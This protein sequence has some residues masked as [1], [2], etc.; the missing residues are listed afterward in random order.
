MRRRLLFAF[1]LL[2][3]VSGFSQGTN[4]TSL[5]GPFGGNIRDIAVHPNGNI[6]VVVYNASIVYKSTDNGATWSEIATPSLDPSI[7]D[8][9]IDASG[10][11]YAVSYSSVYS[12]TDLGV[13]WTTLNSNTGFNNPSFIKK[14]G[15]NLFVLAYSNT[16]GFQGVYKSTN[17]ATSFTLVYSPLDNSKMIYEML[18][19]SGGEVLLKAGGGL[20][21]LRSAATGAA[22]YNSS[23]TGITTTSLANFSSGN[24]LIMDAAGAIYAVFNDNV[25]KSTNSGANWTAI[26]K[27]GTETSFNN[28][29]L[30]A[31]PTGTALFIS[32]NGHT[33]Y[34][35]NSGTSW[36]TQGDLSN[37]S[38]IRATS[39][40]NLLVGTNR[41][42]N[43]STNSGANWAE[44]NTGISGLTF[45]DMVYYN[46][47]TFMVAPDFGLSS[48]VDQGANWIKSASS[49]MVNASNY[50]LL[51][52][53]NGNIFSF[54]NGCDK[55]VDGG[56]TWTNLTVP[57]PFND[58]E[59]YDGTTIYA[60]NGT[61][62]YKSI[63]YGVNWGSSLVFTGLPTAYTV[64]NFAVG[65]SSIFIYLRN[66][67]N[68]INELWK[69]S[70]TTLAA[71]KITAITFFN[72]NLQKQIWSRNGKIYFYSRAIGGNTF[73]LSTSTDD[74]VTWATQNVPLSNRFILASNGYPMLAYYTGSIYYSRDDGAN[75]I[76]VPVNYASLNNTLDLKQAIVDS[77]GNLYILLNGYGLL[78]SSK[79]IILPNPPT[80]LTNVGSSHNRISLVWDDNSNNET[81]FVVERSVGTNTQYDSVGV[82]DVSFLNATPSITKTWIQQ[83]G[84]T[85]NTT[86]FLRVKAVNDAGQ[87]IYSN[88][89][90]VTTPAKCNATIPDNR[91]W[92]GVTQNQSGK[93]V[94]TNTQIGIRYLGNG[95]YSISDFTCG[96]YS[97]IGGSFSNTPIM[98]GTFTENCGITHLYTG[99][100]SGGS[101]ILSN[102][103]STW[104][105]GTNTL[106]LKWQT[107]P[108]WVTL[109]GA[110]FSETVVLTL[111]TTDPTPI[112][113][114][115]TNAFVV[116][117]TGIQVQWSA[118]NYQNQYTIE[119]S[120]SP[121]FA[122][123]ISTVGTVNYPNLTIIDRTISF[124]TNT[125][126]YYRLR[127]SN[128]SGIFSG[129]SSIAS[130]V[131]KKPHFVPINT[132]P[133]T[134]DLA[135]SR[136]SAAFIDFDND[137][138]EDL[139]MASNGNIEPS[140]IMKNNGSGGFDKVLT[141]LPPGT[142]VN[143]S[144]ADFN[145]DGKIDFG[146]TR[147][148]NST[149]KAQV[150]IFSGNGDGTFTKVSGIPA[151]QYYFS[152]TFTWLDYNKDGKLDL[153]FPLLDQVSAS[154]G[155]YSVQLH[156]LRNDGANAF[157]DLILLD[158]G[159]GSIFLND[160]KP[161]DYD[162][163]GDQD[164]LLVGL[165]VGGSG[166]NTRM[167]ANDGTGNFST[168]SIPSLIVNGTVEIYSS[169][170]GDIDNDNDL[171][172]FIGYSGTANAMFRNNGNGTFTYLNTNAV[173]EAI[174]SATYGG[175]WGDI[176]NDGDLDLFVSRA[177]S[178]ITDVQFLYLNDGLGNFTRI[179]GEF[180][181]NYF[182]SN[183]TAAFGDYDRDGYLDL[184]TGFADKNNTI[185]KNNKKITTA[186]N[187][188]QIKL[189]GTVSNRSA[190][191]ARVSLTAAG[192][193]ATREIQSNTGPAYNGQNSFIAHFGLGNATSITSITVTWPSGIVQTLNAPPMNQILTIAEDN[194]GPVISTLS[195]TNTATGVS[196]NSNLEITLTDAATPI[197]AVAGKNILIYLSS[198]LTT[199][200]RTI[201]VNT[202]VQSG[203]K[204][205]LDLATDLQY[206]T[207]YSVAIEAGAFKD[208]YGNGNLALAASD[209]SFTTIDNVPPVIAFTLVPTINKGPT[210]FSA[211][212]T[213]NSSVASA[214]MWH[215]KVSSKDFTE[216]PGTQNTSPEKWDFSVQASD[217]D[218]M[219]I[220][221]YFTAKDASGNS[222]S[223]PAVA[224]EYFTTRINY[225][226][227]TLSLVKGSGAISGYQII[228]IPWEISNKSIAANFEELGGGDITKY[229]FLRYHETPT[230]GWDEYPGAL[231]SFARG[232]GYFLNVTHV[233]EI[234]L[235]SGVAPEE[236][237]NNLFT[238][239]LKKGWN[240]IGNPYLT[241]IQW[242]DVLTYNNITTG[243][244]KLLLFGG[245]KYNNATDP[246]VLEPFKGGFV[247]AD[248]DV[249]GLKIPFQGQTSG[250][251]I[252]NF[253]KELAGEAWEVN[254][255]LQQNDLEFSV[256]SIGMEPRA[257]AGKD[258]FD[259]VVPP[260]LF[261][262]QIEMSVAH[263]EHFMKRFARDVVSTQ[264]EFTWEFNVDASLDATSQLSWDNAAF[265]DNA[266]ELYLFDVVLQKAIDMRTE[267]SYNFNPMESNRFRIYFGEKLKDKIRPDKIFLGKAFP[268]PSTGVSVV[269][270]TLP[271]N[272]S[273]YQVRL[274]VFNML[275][276]KVS[277]LVEGQFKPGFYTT[278]W[279]T[280]EAN[281]NGLYTYRLVVSGE[282]LKDVQSGKII[283]MK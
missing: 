100:N 28:A 273:S 119:R 32:T 237:R 88:E 201:N 168:V 34:S 78:K 155:T 95:E 44:S 193:T 137:G 142:F 258:I 146:G 2:I 272:S 184:A 222:T 192:K 189:V 283:L 118:G 156:V 97:T 55:S 160:V 213:D 191:G 45:Y 16:T 145:N 68:N 83:A 116:D 170:W 203:N 242:N 87:S 84:L 178:S 187:W 224:P 7:N 135:I 120:L 77:Q 261:E 249:A 108:R 228:S 208:I 11:I 81:Y 109:P 65:A 63:D 3:S 111:N 251:R 223:L 264:N 71:T 226:T 210:I 56:T 182:R 195:P 52:L 165:D 130:V 209:W 171:D 59:S 42:I 153:I 159:V 163:D 13:S 30:A 12:S 279:N 167:L 74:G 238:L 173:S 64:N 227:P 256:G 75:W 230:P 5:N 90:T 207:G 40:S 99:T 217:F 57:F 219:G 25:F 89:V 269:P 49:E 233:N 248:A 79:P 149:G 154:L 101:K 60:R 262:D 252:G 275:G 188:S 139:Y 232:E 221:Y 247:Q 76:S 278:E 33:Y 277:T 204:F 15:S 282:N 259:M 27:P 62:F 263:P 61:A 86:Y 143:S 271:E 180:A 240:Q 174:T 10:K 72:T 8:I 241:A 185:L 53:P 200:D 54:N 35:A 225:P 220:Q 176:D 50:D 267:G 190:I 246:G 47:S 18:I 113:P 105:S 162:N 132:I 131:F 128:V 4:W 151:Y 243:V 268:N 152:G 70:L 138:F 69:V 6:F 183:A 41:G 205:T 211:T 26:T 43:I 169:S 236:N 112:T 58:G 206:L 17:D 48:S 212:V 98:P 231:S 218:D 214:S 23:N 102:G 36:T 216:L 265:G 24:G 281:L 14:S 92:T 215:R 144:W 234:V 276:Q 280:T 150:E 254:F 19:N 31:T 177:A 123:G 126:Y 257:N 133:T 104:N 229:R 106:T 122:S 94:L 157:T 82:K 199:P 140:F 115:N 164:L 46:N 239:S 147:Q 235:Q 121:T 127:A 129:Y 166:K 117:D 39:A 266:K 175:N 85:P 270:F 198:N 134:L 73:Q 66:S 67:T 255:L 179:T 186:G 202:L 38:R 158:L 37:V 107:D 21:I 194:T 245:T 136:L 181:T 244:S 93:G 114:T 22:P 274:E 103:T 250:G 124:V 260:P 172:L 141:N 29:V 91:S 20:G 197:S 196:V 1:F 148:D 96:A 253:G 80:N 161:A 51:Y 110:V 125:T 9:E